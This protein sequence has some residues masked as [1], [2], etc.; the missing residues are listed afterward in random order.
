[1][2]VAT[3]TSAC[4]ATT[5]QSFSFENNN[6]AH[7]RDASFSSYLSND[8][9]IFTLKLGESTRSLTPITT[10]SPEPAYQTSLELKCNQ[11]TEIDVFSAEKYFNGGIYKEETVIPEMVGK[12]HPNKDEK[13][14]IPR[15]KTAIKSSTPSVRSEA[16]WNSQSALLPSL[17]KDPS[18]NARKQASGKRFFIGFG[19]NCS[20]KKS[21]DIDEISS[22]SK[23]IVDLGEPRS[24]DIFI[25]EPS[26][27]GRNLTVFAVKRQNRPEFRQREEMDWPVTEKGGAGFNRENCFAFPISNPVAGNVTVGG[28][29][30]VEKARISLE[31]FGTPSFRKEDPDSS[32]Q[33][34]FTTMTLDTGR[35]IENIPA[36]H[37]NSGGGDGEDDL[38]SDASSDLFEIR[39]L[40]GSG[41]PFFNPE[42]P[43]DASTTCYE[44]SEASIEWSVV[45]A[46]AA[47]FSITS[48]FDDRRLIEN[49]PNARNKITTAAKTKLKEGHHRQ[50]SSLLGCKGDKAVKVATDTYRITPKPD[51]HR[52]RRSDSMASLARLQGERRVMDFESAHAQLA[53]GTRSLSR[54]RSAHMLHSLY[55][56]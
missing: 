44:P 25:K 1:M 39:S 41:H 2:A 38:R 40:S 8:D 33:T 45:T 3:V 14:N 51:P 52:H 32:L 12:H 20:G 22:H 35:R 47:N 27:V 26:D 42:A 24:T 4:N 16:S 9:D 23:K 5:S 34:R 11:E 49:D 29:L 56:H 43:D 50:A 21:V 48:D 15:P 55:M 30:E 18:M 17:R 13:I 53:F 28:Q 6:G 10:T 7:L 37:R 31:V 54:S 46:S 36:P 19:C